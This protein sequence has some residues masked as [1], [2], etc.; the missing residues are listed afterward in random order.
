VKKE[1]PYEY[2]EYQIKSR[3][4]NLTDLITT[5]SYEN[6]ELLTEI[7]SI[8]ESFNKNKK[9]LMKAAENFRVAIAN[10]QFL[11]AF[12]YFAALSYYKVALSV[13]AENI[14]VSHLIRNNQEINTELEVNTRAFVRA[15]NHINAEVY[16]IEPIIKILDFTIKF[17]INYDLLYQAYSAKRCDESNI[18]F[19]VEMMLVKFSELIDSI[20]NSPFVKTLKK[21]VESL[22]LSYMSY[23]SSSNILSGAE[24]SRRYQKQRLIE[25]IN[26]FNTTIHAPDKPYLETV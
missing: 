22:M 15:L 5:R 18:Y 8:Y 19:Y 9:N 3:I 24:I 17:Q 7:I 12:K 6:A 21:E 14:S 13:I 25:I 20:Q 1:A 26:S 10:H 16:E 4:K 2:N 23:V 11:E